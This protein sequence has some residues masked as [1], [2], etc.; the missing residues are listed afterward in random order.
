[1]SGSGRIFWLLD[2]N[3]PEISGLELLGIIKK[4]RLPIKTIVIS[5][6]DDFETVK[7]A[8]K[9]GAAD[10]IRKFGLS[11][12]ELTAVL[13]GVLER[14]GEAAGPGGSGRSRR[15]LKVRRPDRQRDS[16]GASARPGGVP[17]RL[18]P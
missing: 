11:K 9:L 5:C 4:R 13:A 2:I 18:L 10:Y 15:S 1:M 6:Y 7:E 14:P 17:D 3:I 12:E 8:M 16:A